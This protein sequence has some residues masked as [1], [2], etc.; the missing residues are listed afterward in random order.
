MAVPLYL[1]VHVPRAI[2]DQ[3]RRRGVDVLTAIDDGY[4]TFADEELLDRARVLG[5]VRFTQDIRFQALAE[6][7]QRQ[8]RPFAGLIFGHQLGATIGRYVNDLELV[9]GASE[10]SEWVGAVDQLPY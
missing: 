3:L 5:R 4:A 7:W 9:A 10:P 8:G 6:E 2:A 1:D